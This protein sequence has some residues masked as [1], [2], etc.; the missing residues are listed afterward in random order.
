MTHSKIK[1]QPAHFPVGTVALF[2]VGGTDEVKE[3]IV[4]SVSC[5]GHQSYVVTDH[6]HE[7]T[8]TYSDGSL[9]SY[10]GAINITHCIG[11]IKRG[12]GPIYFETNAQSKKF[13]N[14]FLTNKNGF[15]NAVF[16]TKSKSQ[17]Y[18]FD[19][20]DFVYNTV[21]LY[22]NNHPNEKQHLIDFDKVFDDLVKLSIFE[23]LP[24][25]RFHLGYLVSKKKFNRV[26][27][28]TIRQSRT[29]VSAAK[30]DWDN[31]MYDMM[32]DEITDD[33]GTL[34]SHEKV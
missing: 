24:Y 34:Y 3:Y 12:D 27:V 11:I 2:Q 6:R 18:I 22:L 17:Y 32:S 5:N 33:N 7:R 10:P 14:E 4:D 26:L 8:Y 19:L 1:W 15:R 25:G 23:T 16:G 31:E 21:Q 9:G 29:S 13:Q 20:R 28:Q 30:R